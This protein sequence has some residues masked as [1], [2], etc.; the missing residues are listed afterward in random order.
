MMGKKASE[1]I[2]E[3]GIYE[4]FISCFTID[5]GGQIQKAMLLLVCQMRTI[6]LNTDK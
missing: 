4:D 2:E 1:I 5:H 3:K 6:F